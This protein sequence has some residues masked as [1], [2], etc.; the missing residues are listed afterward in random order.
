M[1]LR[2]GR[3]RPDGRPTD[4]IGEILR[5]DRIEEFGGGRQ[6]ERRDLE[7]EFAREAQAG[8]KVAGIIHPRVVDQPLPPDGGARFL[9]VDAHENTNRVGQF[10]AQGGQAAGVIE[11]AFRIVDRAGPDNG[12]QA[13]VAPVQNGLRFGAS[14]GHRLERSAA[15]GQLFFDRLGCNEALEATNPRVFEGTAGLLL[16]G[17]GA[18][19]W[20]DIKPEKAP[21]RNSRLAQRLCQRSGRG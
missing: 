13:R 9:E 16:G 15:D 11:G 12:E 1:G 7:E 8:G 20:P 21:S 2:F 4:R 5:N 14:F 3:A 18:V 17:H 6:S 10:T 19:R